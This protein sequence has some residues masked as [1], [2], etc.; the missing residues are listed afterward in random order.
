MELVKRSNWVRVAGVGSTVIVAAVIVLSSD[1]IGQ[2]ADPRA[3]PGSQSGLRLEEMAKSVRLELP[4]CGI[5]GLRYSAK[6]SLDVWLKI[7]FTAADRGCMDRYLDGYKV[8][9]GRPDL[10]WP[11]KLTG[12]LDGKPFGGFTSP[13]PPYETDQLGWS[14][15][16][17]KLYDIYTEFATPV[18]AKFKVVVER[19]SG[20]VQ[21]YMSSTYIVNGGI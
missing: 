5:D 12:T 4:D 18:G 10:T 20:S 16:H 6:K 7:A 21:V 17:A 8:T 3:Y 2:D 9:P 11:Y 19:A 13:F 15:D 14:L 1:L